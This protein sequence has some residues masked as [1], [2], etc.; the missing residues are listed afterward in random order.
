MSDRMERPEPT[1][2]PDSALVPDESLV[3]PAPTEFTHVLTVDEPFNYV[4]GKGSGAPDGEL[5][6]GT[7]VVLVSDDGDVC[8]VVDGRGLRVSIRRAGL[9]SLAG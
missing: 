2:L 3:R 5:A 6:A 1:I 8:Q 9:R 4:G 7:Q